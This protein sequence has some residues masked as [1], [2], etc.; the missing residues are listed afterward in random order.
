MTQH[1]TNR[2]MELF[3]NNELPPAELLAFDRHLRECSECRNLLT[4]MPGDPDRIH[5]L[6]KALG[7][8][9]V[10]GHLT[11]EELAGY[12]DGGLAPDVLPKAESHLHACAACRGEIA[13]F[14]ILRDAT[15]ENLHPA[16]DARPGFFNSLRSM[17]RFP[18]AVVPV[19][20]LLIV[21]AMGAWWI[22]RK[23]GNEN[24][25]ETAADANRRPRLGHSAP[26]PVSSTGETEPETAENMLPENNAPAVMTAA[27]ANPINDGGEMVGLD[28]AGKL[29]GYEDVPPAQRQML[30]RS[31]RNQTVAIG[32]EVTEV[33]PHAGTLMG[34]APDGTDNAFRITGPVGKVISTNRPVLS[35]APLPG[36]ASYTVEV[37]DTKF[38][39]VAASGPLK[40][41]K[42]IPELARGRTY[43]WQV[44]A[45]KDGS[46]IKAPQWPAPEARFHIVD[47]RKLAEIETAKRRHSGSKLL[48]GLLCAR[49]GMLDAAAENFR[50]LMKEN[51]KSAIARKLLQQVQ[52][53][54]SPR[55]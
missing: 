10:G 5:D 25:V 7:G 32:P 19:L 18:T 11:Y 24:N 46:E 36:A 45:V 55:R 21:V 51:P 49:A 47:G 14:A 44:T 39:R 43:V 16:P 40:S 48:V 8:F 3:A 34:A 53:N 35:W 28:R 27:F 30:E 9:V 52:V 42:W 54:S 23:Q 41:T 31:L 4:R 38:N 50:S 15:A 6:R 29:L 20:V 33:K 37:Y 17:F 26:S 12:A 22:S 2:D 1:L 13:Q